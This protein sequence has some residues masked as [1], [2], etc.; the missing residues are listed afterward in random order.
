MAIAA[1]AP[2]ETASFLKE[3][4]YKHVAFQSGIEAKMTV[5]ATAA[6][7]PGPRTNRHHQPTQQAFQLSFHLPVLAWRRD[8][9]ASLD[10]RSLRDCRDIVALGYGAASET[11][12]YEAQFSCM[13]SGTSNGSWESHALFDTYHDDGSS[14]HDVHVLKS[15]EDRLVEFLFGQH[16]SATPITDARDCFLWAM[17]SS[18]QVSCGEWRNSGASLLKAIKNHVSTSRRVDKTVTGNPPPASANGFQ[19]KDIANSGATTNPHTSRRLIHISQEFQYALAR[20]VR[21]WKQFKDTDIAYLSPLS[22]S[23]Q[24][25]VLNIDNDIRD[26]EDIRESLSQQAVILQTLSSSVCP[27][28]LSAGHIDRYLTCCSCLLSTTRTPPR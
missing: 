2:K 9:A 15:N 8:S 1:A 6:L 3:F 18:V 14:K 20:T 25:R 17:E 24:S 13:V 21:A 26:L 16:D 10:S 19:I 12:L 11:Y 27:L 5:S 22:V 28:F 4:L 7:S 23:Q